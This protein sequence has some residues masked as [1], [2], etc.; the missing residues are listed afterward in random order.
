M[1]NQEFRMT[2][3]IE[4]KISSGLL[5]TEIH[6][7]LDLLSTLRVNEKCIRY[8]FLDGFIKVKCNDTLSMTTHVL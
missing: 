3:V 5:S 4:L 6:G 7:Y 8:R 1:A 2:Q